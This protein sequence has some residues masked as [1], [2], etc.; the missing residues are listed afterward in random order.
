MRVHDRNVFQWVSNCVPCV[1]ALCSANRP[2]CLQGVDRSGYHRAR[3]RVERVRAVEVEEAG[4]Q[5][6]VTAHET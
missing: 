4:N 3:E 5:S 2:D 1:R 6:T